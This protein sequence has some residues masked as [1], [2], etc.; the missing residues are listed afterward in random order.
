[1]RG[2]GGTAAYADPS[3]GLAAAVTKNR[4]T[5]GDYTTYNQIAGAWGRVASLV[6]GE[7]PAG[8]GG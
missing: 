1:M 2:S 3:S 6:L 8:W 5:F 4:N 7:F